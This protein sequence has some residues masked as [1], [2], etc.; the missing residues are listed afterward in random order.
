MILARGPAAA[1]RRTSTA[2]VLP[3]VVF[4]GTAVSVSASAEPSLEERDFQALKQAYRDKFYS[5]VKK[6]ALSFLQKYPSSADAGEACF[7]LGRAELETE[8]Y[9]DAARTFEA[10]AKE[11]RGK[12]FEEEA[13][14]WAA[15]TYFRAKDYPSALRYY[16]QVLDKFPTSKYY[17]YARYSDAWALA[18]TGSYDEAI[19]ELHELAAEFPT[20]PLAPEARYKAAQYLFDQKKYEEA[21]KELETFAVDFPLS[22]RV[23][24]ARYLQGESRFQLGQ[25][26]A[27]RDAF[28]KCVETGGE[29]FD[30]AA[31]HRIGWCRF[32]AGEYAEAL[33]AFQA[34]APDEL[35]ESTRYGLARTLSKLGRFSESLETLEGLIRDFPDSD[36][37]DRFYFWKADALYRLDR[38]ADA[39]AVYED[40]LSRHPS[41]QLAAETEYNLG[42]CASKLGHAAEAALHFD[43]AAAA[44]TEESFKVDAYSRAGDV[45]LQAGD[46]EKALAAYDRVLKDHPKFPG[47]D[48]AQYQVGAV[49]ARLGRRDAAV[50]AFQGLLVNYPQSRLRDEASYRIG[51]VLLDAQR[52]AEALAQ[53]E[54]FAQNFPD[55]PLKE[56][57]RFQSA[58]ARFELGRYPEAAEIYRAVNEAEPQSEAG[59][60]SLYQLGRCYLRQG[61]EKEGVAEFESYLVRY[62]QS[63]SVADVLYGLGDNSYNKGRYEAAR[64]YYRRV[65]EDFPTHALADDALEAIARTYEREGDSASAAAKLRQLALSYPGSELAASAS[66]K[67]GDLFLSLGK[68]DDARQEYSRLT[69]AGSPEPERTEAHRKLA[70]I[71]KADGH[72]RE[73]EIYLEEAIKNPP[74]SLKAA[75]EK[76]LAELYE[77][78]GRTAEAAAVREGSNTKR[79]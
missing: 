47:A 73:A 77:T 43:R 11:S 7:L 5:V 9:A 27:A 59:R 56:K 55:S 69:A 12:P 60:M 48:Y 31:R 32:E 34:P 26:A 22:P 23:T 18:E 14:Y 63:E 39:A 57:A 74:V 78:Q 10:L 68:A 1:P 79:G 2:F 28:E 58:N 6:D 36:A 13:F 45:C 33:K 4:L 19:A 24:A 54:K 41:T 17:A 40:I 42:W 44:A 70:A 75:V 53:F 64:G 35:A 67:A 61:M 37:T 46:F 71:L 52:P 3:F 72:L 30:A 21:L 49:L 15:E 62:P 38:P 20:H 16:Q 76:D 65:A 25:Y 51:S 29:E 50:L 66:L 8:K